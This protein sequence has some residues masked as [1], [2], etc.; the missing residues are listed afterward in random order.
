MSDLTKPPPY[1]Y[2]AYIDEA[3]DPGIRRVSPRDNPGA[4]EWLVI[5]AAVIAA[6]RESEPAL[7]VRNILDRV[8]LNQNPTLHFRDLASWRKP[9]VCHETAKLPVRL[10]AMVSNKKNMK[11][12][13]NTRAEARSAGIPQDQVFYN[14]CIRIILERITGWCYRDSIKRFGGPRHVK[15]LLSERGTHSYARAIWY[16]QILK[17]Q[18]KSGTT[19]IATRTINWQ[20]FDTRLIAVLQHQLDA[21]LQLAD[22]VASSFYQAVNV[23]APTTWDS[24]NARLLMPRVV[25]LN[26]TFENHGLTFLPFNYRLAQLH[27]EQIDIFEAYG[28]SRSKF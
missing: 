17:D 4:S 22:V 13:R 24:N 18:S 21:G 5:G 1:E 10:F 26:G 28:F 14:W 25:R 11:G 8:G 23:L 27:R 9:V 15:V 7:W 19:F 3:G 2:I 20:V 12:H 6:P 16:Q